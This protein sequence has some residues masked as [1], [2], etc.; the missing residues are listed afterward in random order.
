MRYTARNKLVSLSEGLSAHPL[1]STYR[2]MVH[3]CHNPND[4]RYAQYGGRGI[5]V[6]RRWMEAGNQ[7]FLNF[8]ADMGPRPEGRTKK[9]RPA[10]S[11]ERIDNNMGYSPDNCRWGTASEQNKNK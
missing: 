10:Y 4:P 11:L 7:G 5:R 2:N 3:R 6:C 9:R 1:S 8:I